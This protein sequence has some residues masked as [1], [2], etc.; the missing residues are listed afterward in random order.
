MEAFWKEFYRI[1]FLK[2][3]FK[4]KYNN[5]Q[6]IFFWL[7]FLWNIKCVIERVFH[8]RI[9]RMKFMKYIYIYIYIYI[10]LYIYIYIYIYIIHFRGLFPAFQSIYPVIP[11]FFLFLIL[12]KLKVKWRKRKNSKKLVKSFQKSP[13]L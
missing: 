2:R 11:K 5:F 1:S 7:K 9:F 4:N 3:A 12:S 8:N 10:Y 13:F 6:N